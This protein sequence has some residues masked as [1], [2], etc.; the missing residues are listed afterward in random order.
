MREIVRGMP[1]A[2]LGVMIARQGRLSPITLGVLVSLVG[3]SSAPL[4]HDDADAA[5]SNH[6]GE[7][8]DAGGPTKVQRDD[9]GKWVT[10]HDAASTEAS[11]RPDAQ[12]EAGSGSRQFKFNPGFYIGLDTNTSLKA[13]LAVVDSLGTN[14]HLTGFQYFATWASLENPN[15]PGDYSG[16]WDST[17]ASGFVAVDAMVAACAKY[18]KHLM[19]AV[20]SS[21]YGS[22]DSE[23]PVGLVPKYLESS[24]YGATS[25]TLAT[26]LREGGA[27]YTTET[28]LAGD[29]VA[30]A[31]WWDAPV[32]AR[33]IALSQA[34]AARYDDNP[35]FE[36]FSGL[37]ESAVPA[38]AG[39]SDVAALS[40]LTGA[41]GYFSVTRKAW[42]NTMLRWAGNYTGNTSNVES[43]VTAAVGSHFSIG[44]PDCTNETGAHPRGFWVDEVYRGLTL[45]LDAGA[46]GYTD[47]V[48]KS[49]W[50]SEV[51]Y[52]DLGPN[53]PAETLP[54]QLGSGLLP[55]ILAHANLQGATHMIWWI[56]N[57]TGPSANRYPGASP[58]LIDFLDES[59]LSNTTYPP[60]FPLQGR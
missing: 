5:E 60:L 42:P 19:L 39:Y 14:S 20:S 29:Y 10:S 33:M 30:T 36:M 35:T 28:G 25:G 16:S 13:Q 22:G 43:F 44:G 21:A 53:P 55:D 56:E 54:A 40:Q 32:M 59:A 26:G 7:A 6:G 46:S 24:T 11:V 50:I 49:G 47:Y 41:S 2:L 48:G 45:G 15:V 17:G 23:F 12:V 37:G 57:Y 4:A 1:P 27:W 38:Q 9:G 58:N 8:S 18:G 51:Q 34:F 3:C 31:V 52:P